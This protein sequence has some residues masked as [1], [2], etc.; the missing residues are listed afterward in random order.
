[1]DFSSLSGFIQQ[2]PVNRMDFLSSDVL[3]VAFNALF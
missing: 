1:M 3:L 2:V